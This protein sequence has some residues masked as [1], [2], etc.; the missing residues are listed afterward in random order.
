MSLLRGV[1]HC[2]GSEGCCLGS[3]VVVQCAGVI[4]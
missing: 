3:G 4:A 1:G 2:L